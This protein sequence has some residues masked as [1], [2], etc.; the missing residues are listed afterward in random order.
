M[1]EG[2]SSGLLECVGEV[3]RQCE[4]WRA[5][6]TAAHS[7]V[8][9]TSLVLSRNEKLQSDF[10]CCTSA[11]HAMDAYSEF[12]LNAFGAQDAFCG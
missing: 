2:D 10:F 8:A 12:P 6:D 3:L 7:P 11:I 1:R 5:I 4:V 9:G